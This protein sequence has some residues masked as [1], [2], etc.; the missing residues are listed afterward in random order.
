MPIGED[1]RST[2]DVLRQT[3][4]T[5]G[6]GTAWRHLLGAPA[7]F[8]GSGSSHCLA[9]AAAS[10]YEAH[11]GAPAQGMLP[12]EYRSRPGW[13]HVGFSRTGQTTELIGAM[14]RAREAGAPVLLLAGDAGSPAEAVADR[15]LAL[16]FAAERG[17]V[18]TRFI[19]ACLAALRIILAAE[20]L[21]GLPEAIEVGLTENLS[22]LRAPH[23]VYLGRD[24]RYGVARSAALTLEESALT[25]A[26]SHQTLDYRHGPIACADEETLVWCF[27]QPEEAAPVLRDVEATGATVRATGEDPL[28]SLVQ[29]QLLAV[30]RA[31]ARGIDPDA[32]RHLSRAVVLEAH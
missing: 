14:R 4:E 31:A 21:T 27:D 9:L 26:E 24:W 18:Q 10:L 12:S 13:L 7:V 19:T 11:V 5:V 2:P 25:V 3:I 17:V 32:P 8:L 30:A 22:S 1:I 20:D 29:A 15:T 23:V 16:P 6:A 28:V